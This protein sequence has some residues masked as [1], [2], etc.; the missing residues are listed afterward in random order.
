MN[1][2]LSNLLFVILASA[3]MGQII[4]M[5]FISLD[6]IQLGLSWS[7]ENATDV[8]KSQLIYAFS[9][10]SM[11]I[12]ILIFYLQFKRIAAQKMFLHRILDGLNEK[13]VVF[14]RL[15]IPTF[16][17]KAFLKSS[18]PFEVDSLFQ[19]IDRSDSFEWACEDGDL[20]RIF[21][22]SFNKLSGQ[23]GTI[24][25]LD[26]I[27]E[28]K[29][30]DEVIKTQEKNLISASRLASLG[31]MAAGVAHE[32]NNPL[33]VIIG[34][35]EMILT[36]MAEG[37]ATEVDMRKAISKINDMAQRISKVVVSMRKVSRADAGE[38]TP[39]KLIFAIEDVLNLSSEKI[40]LSS[41]EIDVSGLRQDTL[42]RINFSQFSQVL[43]NLI[44]NSIDE[45][46]KNPDDN[47]KIWIQDEELNGDIILKIRDSGSGI[48]E[49][50]RAKLFQP[51][52]TTKEIGKGTGLGLSIS[53][54]LM[55]GMG[56][57]LVLSPDLTQTCFVLKLKKG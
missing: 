36:Q 21:L 39:T 18:L 12:I 8:Y 7:L 30:R 35:S 27:T 50:V 40:R 25:I 32:I 19:F 57:D 47:K 34:R 46:Q 6:L 37:S 16:K 49:E 45:L 2:K 29:R 17:N 56:G 33:A 11:P 41:I 44:T 4:P 52:F 22:C 43:I 9:S 13:I 5:L 54:S 26:E 23:A 3:L 38:V 53:K 42:V 14:N 48:P 10:I 20:V 51:F 1:L 24:L 55:V 31:E 28:T 15:R